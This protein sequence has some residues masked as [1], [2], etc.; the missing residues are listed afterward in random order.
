MKYKIDFENM[1][2]YVIQTPSGVAAAAD[3]EAMLLELVNS[4]EWVV[5]TNRLLDF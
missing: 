5:G 2:D 3:Y 4:P 1:P